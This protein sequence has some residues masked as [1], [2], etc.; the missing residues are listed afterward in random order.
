[1]RFCEI[2][3]KEIGEKE[4]YYCLRSKN[5]GIAAWFP[6]CKHGDCYKQFHHK[7]VHESFHP[8]PEK[9]ESRF[10]ILDL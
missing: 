7:Y 2:C 1:M 8:L 4:I 6:V 5:H 10:E 3:K 9:I